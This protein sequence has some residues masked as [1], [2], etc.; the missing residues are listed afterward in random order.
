MVAAVS[1][2]FAVSLVKL[3]EYEVEGTLWNHAVL[4]CQVVLEN[5]VKCH[6]FHQQSLGCL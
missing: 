2:V 6:Q 1:E 3:T 5:Q 4:H